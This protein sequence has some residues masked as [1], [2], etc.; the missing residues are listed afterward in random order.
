MAVKATAMSGAR[1]PWS[2]SCNCGTVLTQAG[3]PLINLTIVSSS[4]S[5]SPLLCNTSVS[6]R[7]S[8]SCP[9]RNSAAKRVE[10]CSSLRMRAKSVNSV[11]E[12]GLSFSMQVLAMARAACFSS[13]KASGATGQQLWVASARRPRTSLNVSCINFISS[14]RT[15]HTASHFRISLAATL[16]N[17]VRLTRKAFS[18]LARSSHKS[19][20]V[21][22]PAFDS[23][24]FS[25]IARKVFPSC[26]TALHN[27]LARSVPNAGRARGIRNSFQK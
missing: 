24:S 16:G 19:A 18:T 25:V 14:S 10:I 13:N 8:S 9:C 22:S 17:N 6:F 15:A 5:S 11:A 20:L 1:C 21:R 2:P 12:S 23:Q 4:N 3:K 26:L 7:A 27:L